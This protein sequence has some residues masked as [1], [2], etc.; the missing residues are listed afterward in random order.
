M[1][2]LVKKYY[3]EKIISGIWGDDKE[4]VIN[5]SDA[6]NI[7]RDLVEFKNEICSD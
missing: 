4:K 6:I 3:K 7:L 1:G 2:C 5:E